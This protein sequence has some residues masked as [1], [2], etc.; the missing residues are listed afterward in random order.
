MKYK[1][2]LLLSV[3]RILDGN[4]F[5]EVCI[6]LNRPFN[7]LCSVYWLCLNSYL[8]I[9]LFLYNSFWWSL[10]SSSF[11]SVCWRELCARWNFR[12]PFIYSVMPRAL[13]VSGGIWT[14]GMKHGNP[15]GN[16][17]QHLE[18]T[19]NHTQ[20]VTQAQILWGMRQSY[21]RCHC[22]GRFLSNLKQSEPPFQ[23]L[24]SRV[25]K[26]WFSLHTKQLFLARQKNF[27]S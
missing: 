17:I 25:K 5:W 16:P 27:I 13:S 9:Q 11:S 1:P 23:F 18:N 4:V 22:V 10:L 14:F 3:Y 2:C 12:A 26:S 15:G 20:A 19:L 8:I 21:P 6:D 7:I 24:P